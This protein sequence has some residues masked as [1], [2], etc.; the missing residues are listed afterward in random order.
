MN[1]TSLLL[2]VIKATIVL[3]SAGLLAF[4]MRRASAAMRNLIWRA[5]LAGLVV[6]PLLEKVDWRWR[7]EV[8]L[9]AQL[10]QAPGRFVID[11]TANAPLVWNPW[12]LLWALGALYFLIRGAASQWAAWRLLRD[13]RPWIRESRL[14]EDAA[15][16]MV[17]GLAR[18]GIVL[19]VEAETWSRDRLRSVLAHERMHLQR[20]DL[21]WQALAQLVCALYWPHP[22]VWLAAKELRKESE[23]ACDDG[24]LD[25]GVSAPA[26]AGHLVEVAR[27]IQPHRPAPEGVIAMA[28]MHELERRVHALLNPQLNRRGAG[29]RAVIVT[30]LTAL[31]VLTPLAAVRLTAQAPN[32]LTGVVVDASGATVPKAQVIVTFAPSAGRKEFT[33]T[34]DVGEFRFEPIPEGVYSITVRKPGFAQ[35]NMTGVEL[36]G[37]NTAPLRLTLNVGQIQ[38]TVT[39]QGDRPAA[40]AAAI[41]ATSRSE[42]PKRIQV[43]GFVQQANLLEKAT[44]KY[45][46][47]CKAEG[48]EGTVLMKAVISREGTVLSL[49]PINQLVDQRLVAAATEAVKQWKYRPTLLNGNPIEV[50]TEVQVNFTLSR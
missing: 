1:S 5:A 33:L 6:L 7:P 38:E 14:S 27:G 34:N 4:A 50:V 48:V 9:P 2:G 10:T 11:V 12:V 45:P 8:L 21:R 30:M 35:L 47:E 13:A 18:S 37:A 28:R 36:K 31:M 49:E 44:P 3:A 17:C 26:Y 46:A 22:G 23:Q 39:V 32:R 15:V 29:T 41:A 16:P 24:V 40:A 42:E 19:P 20:N 25:T 43:G